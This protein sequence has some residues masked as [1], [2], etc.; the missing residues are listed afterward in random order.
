M[1]H[2][3]LITVGPTISLLAREL[4]YPSSNTDGPD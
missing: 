1:V 4:D 3:V 2:V